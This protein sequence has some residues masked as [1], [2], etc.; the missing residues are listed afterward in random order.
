M[1]GN[2]NC[3]W[4]SGCRGDDAHLSLGG[5]CATC[6]ILFP[7]S[8]PSSLLPPSSLPPFL[9]PPSF[10]SSFLHFF[11]KKS[12]VVNGWVGKT[13][14]TGRS[15]NQRSRLSWESHTVTKRGEVEAGGAGVT[16]ELRVLRAKLG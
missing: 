16:Q 2:S 13:Q 4:F 14:G 8:L 1:K 3:S 5:F 9:F 12:R 10:L 15:R 11:S 7:S 6:K